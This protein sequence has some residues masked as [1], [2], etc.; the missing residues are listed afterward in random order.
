M[1]KAA[2]EISQFESLVEYSEFLCEV[3]WLAKDFLDQQ[4]A[5]LV[6]SYVD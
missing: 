4:N 3:S 5:T 1:S 6:F 2:S